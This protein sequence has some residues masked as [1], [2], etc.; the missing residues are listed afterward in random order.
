MEKILANT[1]QL[2]VENIQV[3]Y[4]KK[5][6]IEDLTMTIPEH[7]ISIFIGPNGCGKST[8]L[9]AFAR[10]LEPFKGKRLLD[11]KG[12][13]AYRSKD[14]AK[15]IGLLPQSPLVPEGVKVSELVARG[16]YPYQEAFQSLKNED[17]AAIDEAMDMMGIREYADRNVDELSGGQ[18]QRVWI[19]MT[20][21]QQTDILFLDEPTSGVDVLTRR[22]FW[23]HITSLAKKGVTI[24]VT[25]HFMDEAEYCDR[26]S[27]FYKGETI[28]VGTPTE[29]KQ[30]AGA[31]DME[32][33][34]INLIKESEVSKWKSY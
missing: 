12:Y 33:A 32:T 22:D 1:H 19:A 16:R 28:A 11:K 9:K 25:T 13:D 14:L 3:G 10:L 20:L 17:Y 8:L 21:A 15:I 23:N 18:R 2:E 31:N 6:I 7:K 34:F 30:Q 26:I 29:L 27:L 24:M 4:D 5:V